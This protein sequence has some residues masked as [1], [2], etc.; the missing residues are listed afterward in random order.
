MRYCL[1]FIPLGLGFWATCVLAAPTPA[2]LEFFEK[3]IRPVLVSECYKC[4]SKEKKVKGELRL[5]WRGGWQ[6]G[7]ESGAAII[8]G[9]VGKSLLIQ[10]IRHADADLKM[11]PKKK[12][13]AAQI[14]DFEKWV[15]MGAPDP[16]TT[17]EASA[18]EKEL[19]LAAAR[20]FWA[21]QPARKLPAPKVKQT[22]WSHVGLLKTALNDLLAYADKKNIKDVFSDWATEIQELKSTYPL[23]YD[24]TSDLIQ[25]QMVL[26]EIN[27]LTKG[28][29][30]VS[31]G[32]GQHQM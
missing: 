1:K 19:D 22:D 3:K 24:R 12:L 8:P 28:N 9:R 29:A 6:K 17:S 14:S 21:F 16:R 18:E 25:P 7:G 5:D 13:S 20:K 30:I 10:A 31:T 27:H 26:D 2:E 4:H 11:P 15:A 32:V 23:D